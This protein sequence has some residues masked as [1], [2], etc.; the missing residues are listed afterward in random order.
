MRR[1]AIMS[2]SSKDRTSGAR[3]PGAA[4]SK[5]GPSRQRGPDHPGGRLGQRLAL[6]REDPGGLNLPVR[7]SRHAGVRL[8]VHRAPGTHARDLAEI[9]D[10]EFH[11]GMSR[12]GIEGQVPRA[13]QH[14]AEAEL[15]PAAFP[16]YWETMK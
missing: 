4:N 1:D 7:R 11:V 10:R 8:D 5:G 2:M 15:E 6:W 9:V 16:L 14:F 13:G 3:S 12:R